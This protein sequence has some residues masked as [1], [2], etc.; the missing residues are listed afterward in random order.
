MYGIY[1]KGEFLAQ[2]SRFGKELL[3]TTTYVRTN[4]AKAVAR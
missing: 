3:A 2:A 4:Y 1:D